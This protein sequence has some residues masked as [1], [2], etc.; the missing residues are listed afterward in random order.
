MGSVLIVDDVAGNARLVASLLAPDGYAVRT[1]G[2]GAEALRLVR[3]DP[4][5]LVL[6]DVMMPMVDGFEACRAIKRDPRHPADPGR[7]GDVAGR[8]QRA[9]SAASTPARTTSSAS[10]STPR[11]FARASA[12]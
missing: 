8:H 7:A 4:P 5:D 6:M 3:A 11:S 9:G 1:A 12:R 2:D 10:R